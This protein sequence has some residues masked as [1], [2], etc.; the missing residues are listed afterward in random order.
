M[1]QAEVLTALNLSVTMQFKAYANKIAA[2]LKLV[3]ELEKMEG[4]T[5]LLSGIKGNLEM[6]KALPVF[7]E[8]ENY[9]KRYLHNEKVKQQNNCKDIF[10]EFQQWDEITVSFIGRLKGAIGIFYKI[11]DTVQA[12]DEKAAILALYD[13]YEHIHQPKVKKIK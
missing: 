7:E 4:F 6:V 1:K 2:M 5:V 13:K 10:G 11:T 12:T 3:Q 9:S 8:P